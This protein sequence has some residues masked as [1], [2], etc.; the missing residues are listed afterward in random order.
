MLP[1]VLSFCEM[2]GVSSP[3]LER[4]TCVYKVITG[5]TVLTQAVCVHSLGLSSSHRDLNCWLMLMI[6]QSHT[7][8]EEADVSRIFFLGK[9]AIDCKQNTQMFSC[10][11]PLVLGALT[12]GLLSLIL[13]VEGHLWIHIIMSFIVLFCFSESLSETKLQRLQNQTSFWKRFTP[14]ELFGRDTPT[15]WAACRVCNVLQVPSLYER[16][17]VLGWA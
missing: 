1:V 14:T 16:S 13:L 10:L 12:I 11:F 9:Q 3:F 8:T 7:S 17:P 5:S 6:Y 2:K 15:G 4:Q